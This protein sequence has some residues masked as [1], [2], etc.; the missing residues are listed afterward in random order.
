MKNLGNKLRPEKN[1]WKSLEIL[2]RSSG[3]HYL[4]K[5]SSIVS[6]RSYIK[7]RSIEYLREN[8]ISLNL[9]YKKTMFFESFSTRPISSQWPCSV[10]YIKCFLLIS[11][12]RR[13]TGNFKKGMQ[14]CLPFFGT[15]NDRRNQRHN[16]LM[17]ERRQ[18]AFFVS[19]KVSRIN[20]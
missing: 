4:G 1:F 14:R 18:M 17:R 10:F 3:Q 16:S 12:G 20:K 15:N 2:K 7:A 13:A 9:L 11:N 8:P 5:R 19:H 6:E